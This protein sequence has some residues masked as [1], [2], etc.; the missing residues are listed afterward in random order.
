MR[1]RISWL[2]GGPLA[3]LLLCLLTFMTFFTWSNSGTLLDEW[4]LTD[5]VNAQT[6][7]PTLWDRAP[8]V[9]LQENYSLSSSWAGN[10]TFRITTGC[11]YMLEPDW[12]S[13]ISIKCTKEANLV[14]FD[15]ED[16]WNSI[17]FW[18]GPDEIRLDYKYNPE[19]GPRPELNQAEVVNKYQLADDL[20][21]IQKRVAR[22]YEFRI[23]TRRG[24][25]IPYWI[26]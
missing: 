14:L 5:T 22:K 1:K 23:N 21:K 13:T 7:S 24:Y 3:G 15:P 25:V 12:L 26:P 6:N 8:Y 2:A 18:I 20:E 11:N 4:A 16:T 9:D 19:G 10:N 17:Q